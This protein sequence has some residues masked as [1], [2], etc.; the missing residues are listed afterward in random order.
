[1]YNKLNQ[2]RVNNKIKM[3]K[4]EFI[5]ILK[6]CHKQGVAGDAM[7]ELPLCYAKGY[8]EGKE[9]DAN[10]MGDDYYYEVLNAID[11][12]GDEHFV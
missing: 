9:L 5:K 12:M 10:F 2:G 6:R 3:K 8:L 1:M 4:E 7:Y 11:W